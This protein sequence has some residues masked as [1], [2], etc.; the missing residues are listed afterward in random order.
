MPNDK[1]FCVYTCLFGDYEV[2]NE[3]PVAEKS[4]IEFICFTDNPELTSNTWKIHYI[5][6][7]FPLDLA[8]SSRTLKICPHRFLPDYSVSLY[9]DNS[10][11]L[12]V[13]P[14]VIFEE[15]YSE[16]HDM[17]LINHSFRDTVMDEFEEVVR[18][19]YDKPGVVLE[20][21]NTYSIISPEIYSQKPYWGGFI[22]RKH[23]LNKIVDAMEDWLAQVY[24]YSKRD[25]LS[26]N[27]IINKHN[28]SINKYNLSNQE[29]AYHE[30]PTAHRQ[31][32]PNFK[33]RLFHSAE[34]NMR[35]EALAHKLD[36]KE[37]LIQKINNNL[38]ECEQT[39]QTLTTDLIELEQEVLFYANSKSW[40]ITRPLRRFFKI[41]KK[42]KEIQ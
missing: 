18:I 1:G 21:L 42:V 37:Q 30:W 29:S 34:N 17:G 16:A 31:G 40:R 33:E 6:P 22:I 28:L 20:Q 23:N 4:E 26:I 9:I 2:L 15:L 38:A 24:R 10:V 32:S 39:K 14:E 8:R 35:A 19:D 13:P 27:H 41:L 11:R 3:Q 12:K 25:Q 7:V 36:Q 5:S